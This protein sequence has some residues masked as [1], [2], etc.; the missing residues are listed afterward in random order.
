[1]KLKPKLKLKL[2]TKL[3]L[4]LIPAAAGLCVFYLIP[5]IRVIYYS[6]LKD[7]Y[8]GRFAG[9][10]NYAAVL[11]ND[12]FRKAAINTGKMIL[13]CVPLFLLGTAG[14]SLLCYRGKKAG[15]FLRR[16]SI[17]PLFLPSFCVVGAFLVFFGRV[18][19][20]WPIYLLFLWKYLGM[21]III[22]FSAFEGINPDFYDAARTEGAS[23]PQIYVRITLP[24]IKRPI[25]F[26][27]ILGIVYCFRTFRES[28]LYYGTNYPPDYAYTLQYYMNNQFLKLN[29][30]N[31][32]AASVILT[33]LLTAF[34]FLS[35]Y[36]KKEDTV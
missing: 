6:F 21:G 4:C 10:A 17:L 24:L 27:V 31:M 1:M 5:F 25:K 16:V 29:Y 12:Y 8:Q 2:N 9:A 36:R 32:A 14:I 7:I 28:Y 22:L 20:E 23:W 18:E 26:V 33:V 15:V 13:I 30:Q 34:L 35:L 11:K 3:K 19:N